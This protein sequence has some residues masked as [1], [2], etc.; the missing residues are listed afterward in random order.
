MS[1]EPSR[2]PSSDPSILV[3]GCSHLVPAAPTPTSSEQESVRTRECH[4]G[5]LTASPSEPR[6]P[7]DSL[8]ETA[9]AA[10]WAESEVST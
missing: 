2:I 4:G 9:L 5:L 6:L 7:S 3:K 1:L 8:L 10:K